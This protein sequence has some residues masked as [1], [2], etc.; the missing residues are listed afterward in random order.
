MYVVFS[1]KHLLSITKFFSF[2]K[3]INLK[4]YLKYY[5]VKQNG[6]KNE[7]IV[8]FIEENILKNTKYSEPTSKKRIAVGWENSYLH[9][10]A[11][12][13]GNETWQHFERATCAA[14]KEQ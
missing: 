11:L 1:W 5:I 2:L 14:E 9:N 7:D 4:I 3:A 6:D 13:R 8:I 10:G 12:S